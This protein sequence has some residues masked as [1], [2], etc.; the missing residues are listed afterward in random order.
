MKLLKNIDVKKS[1]GEYKLPPKLVKC[2][3]SYIY[4]SLTLIINQ[5]LKTSTFQNNAK[6]AVVPRL[7]KGSLDKIN[8]NNFR[9]VNVLNCFSKIFENIMKGQ[10]L[11]YIE[12]HL[13]VFLSAYRSSYSSQ[14]VL[15]CLIEEWRQKL[16]SDHFV[17]AVLMDFSKALDCIPHDLL[18]AKLSE[19][20][21]SNEA[22][23]YI[24]S[25]LTGR[26]NPLK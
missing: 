14:H 11:L 4:K 8:I 26:N 12:N 24:F 17:G 13:S 16:D 5:S 20:G 23:A 15:I 18:M 6:R 21:F 7:G 2:A 9:P 1:T 22:L 10:L 25:Y 19:Y 3:V